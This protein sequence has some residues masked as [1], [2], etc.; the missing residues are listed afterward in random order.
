MGK[1]LNRSDYFFTYM[2]IISFACLIGGF[3]LGAEVMKVRSNNEMEAMKKEFN[4]KIEQDRL[5]KEKKLYKEQDFVSFYYNVLAPLEKFKKAHFAYADKLPAS[6][7]KEIKSLSSDALDT[8]DETLKEIEQVSI[9][10]SSPLLK[11]AKQ[12]YIQSLQ[13]YM[14]GMN[15]VIDGDNT[16]MT[17]KELIQL[18]HLEAFKRTWLRAQADMYKAIAFWEEMYVTNQPLVRKISQ[19]KI[20]ISQWKSYPFHLRD[21]I[22]AEHLYRANE[23]VRFNPEDLTSRV[24]VV[25]DGNQAAALGW[26]DIPFAFRVLNATDAVREGDFKSLKNKLYSHL[27][28][29]EMPLFTE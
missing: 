7:E 25:V 18:R 10:D 26:K 3:F 28:S 5:E 16:E 15:E 1:R 11:Q 21:Y 19:Q 14:D 22:A 23:M 20:S 13:A 4:L 8:A 9:P 24:D 27:K 6:S 29:P 17:T 2:I 12:E